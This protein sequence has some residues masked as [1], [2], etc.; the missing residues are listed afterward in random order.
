M[1][2]RKEK[3]ELLRKKIRTRNRLLAIVWKVTMCVPRQGLLIGALSGQNAEQR[4]PSLF[5]YKSSK[6]PSA[7]L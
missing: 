6:T 2:A 5:C 1:A 3:K 7:T 4:L